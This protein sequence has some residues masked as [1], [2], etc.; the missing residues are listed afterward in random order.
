VP[1]GETI[2]L[3]TEPLCE[4]CAKSKVEGAPNTY[5]QADVERRADPTVCG[6]CS[7]DH[8]SGELPLLA[9][10]PVCMLC[11]P[12]LRNREFPRWI[13]A[14]AL[15][16]V[17]ALGASLWVGQVYVDAAVAMVK[18]ERELEAKHPA[19]ASRLLARTLELAP[20]SAKA[21]HLKIKADLLAGDPDAALELIDVYGDREGDDKLVAEINEI[22]KRVN[23]AGEKVE[24]AVELAK[25]NRS[26]EALVLVRE[27]AQLYPEWGMTAQ[28]IEKL[29]A[30]VAFEAKDYDRFLT[31]SEAAAEKHPDSRH[32][33]AVASAL[34]TKYAETGEDGYRARSEET[35]ERARSLAATDAERAEFDEYSERI[36]HRLTS[37][38]I[39][40]KDEYDRRYRAQP[41]EAKP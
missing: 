3:R 37:R 16:L 28:I 9:G 14:S 6:F 38:E 4:A 2:F 41:E 15:A 34:A 39:I 29:E 25:G 26:S 40:E 5:T 19:E 1:L 18:A 10:V 35:L 8:G 33:A 20:D 23:A 32:T 22:L 36:R 21:G 31:L 12:R 30:S 7:T 24:A 17:A 11:E 27:A 13:V